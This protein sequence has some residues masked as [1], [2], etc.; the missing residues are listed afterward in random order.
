MAEYSTRESNFVTTSSGSSAYIDYVRYFGAIG[1]V[2]FHSGL[3]GGFIGLAALPLFA[4][5]LAFFI[6][7]STKIF[8]RKDYV[9]Q[10]ASRLLIPWVIWSGV[11]GLVKVLDALVSRNYVDNQ[12]K[13]WMFLTGPSIHLWFL[14][15]AFLCSVILYAIVW[16]YRHLLS[17]FLFSV[18]AFVPI[19]I[20]CFRIQSEYELVIPLAQWIYVLPSVVY[21]AILALSV[22]STFRL[23][24][25][26]AA[27]II[28]CITV[29][30]SGWNFGLLQFVISAIIATSAIIV[31]RP[32]TRLS[33]ALGKA[34]LGVY[35]IHPLML[36]VSARLFG[37][38]EYSFLNF[39]FAVVTS[40]CLSLAFHLNS[41]LSRSV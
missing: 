5:L 25:T 37:Q 7:H 21:G 34:S 26:A 17:C 36:S 23:S 20:F 38:M 29:F 18:L 9:F 3:P 27:A 33:S 16:P 1:I 30:Q 32:S 12:F 24:L 14:P 22:G 8:S 31:F 13:W 4:L 28:V 40:T 19:S 39:A 10:R 41:K 2:L 15:F 11:Y 35:L 6:V